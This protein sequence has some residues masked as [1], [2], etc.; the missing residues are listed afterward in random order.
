MSTTITPTEQNIE[1]NVNN[2]VIDINVTNEIVDVNATTQQIDINIA[3]AYPL[4]SSV[5]SVFGRVGDVVATEGDYTLTQLGDVTLTSPSNGQVLKYNG[6]AWV[7]STDAGGITTLNTLT[8]LSQT[9]ATGTSGTDFNI[10]SATSTH[11]FNIPTASATNRGALSSSD[12]SVFNAKEPAIAA[13]TTAEYYRGDKTFQTLNTTA[14]PEGTNLYYTDARV[15][16]N[17]NVAANTAARHNAV[18]LGTANGLS[19]STQILSLAL[20]SGSTTG[21]LSSTDWNTFNNKQAAGNYVTLDTFQTIT[22]SKT[23]S[24]GLT[25]ASAGGTNQLTSFVNTDSI[26][27]GS[28]GS[29][30]LGFNNSNNIYFG[31]GLDN[32]GVISWN[33]SAVRYYALPNADGTIALTSDI[34]SLTG[35]VPYTGAT[36][37]LNLGTHTLIA[38]KGT[39]SSSGSGDTVGITHSSGSGIALNITKGGNGEGLYI[40]KT[41]GSGNAATIIGTLNAT[42]LVKSGGTSSQYLMADGS[43]STLT[44]PITG[45]GTTNTLPKFTGASTIGNSNI[46]DTGSLI[47]LGSNSY[48]NGSLGIGVTPLTQISLRVTKNITGNAVSSGITQGGT[49]Q[50]DVTTLGRGIVNTLSTQAASFTLPDYFYFLATQGTIGAGSAVTSQI[51]YY[52]DNTLTGAGSNF[53]FRGDIPSGTNRWNLYMNGTANNYL[54]GSLGIGATN[55]VEY[56]LR[57]SKNITGGTTARGCVSDGTIQSSV[58]ANAVGLGTG[59]STAAASFTLLNLYQFY[60]G[61]GTIGAGSTVTNQYGYHADATLIGATNN[62]GFRGAIPAG[63]N[64]WNLYMN[65]TANNYMAGSLGIGTTSIGEYSLRAARNITGSTNSYAIRQDGTVL[66]DVTSNAYGYSNTLRT[67][68]ASFTLNNYYHYDAGQAASLGAGSV[69]TNQYGFLAQNSLIGATNNFGFRG[70]IPSGTNRWNLYMAGTAANYMAGKTGVGTT[71]LGSYIFNVGGSVAT[72]VNFNSTNASGFY[73]TYSTSG[74]ERAYIGLGANTISGL[75]ISDLGIVGSANVVIASGSGGTET[76]RIDST[77]RIGI[78]TGAS[79]NASAKVQIDSTTSGFLPPRMTT[80]QR[81]AIS[82]PA[83]GLVVYDTT[84]NVMTYYNGTLWIL[85]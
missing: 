61:Q 37:N 18:T 14:V 48:I 35:Y 6:T 60:S 5:F 34:P 62:Y 65:G 27:S 67:Q 38:A 3:G 44:N 39:F 42:T 49:V 17:T 40:N 74:T 46:T 25:L 11:T 78:G 29:N 85:F 50:S 55:L 54:A 1:I 32:G 19:L 2:D 26:H 4:P 64:R 30:I 66:S 36:A 80:T 22:A 16:A 12:W 70:D 76:M 63:T 21:A 31:K 56:S 53:G 81:T 43:V 73:T 33:N 15:N 77:K 13:G 59:L 75:A 8:A 71:T 84:L 83:A 23:F 7:N 69:V 45:T 82:S 72:L 79:I 57:I 10:S 52:V 24:V 41:S 51:G 58:T 68:A 20:A 28:A 47:T 9:F